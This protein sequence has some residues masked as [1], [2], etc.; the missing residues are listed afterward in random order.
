MPVATASLWMEGTPDAGLPRLEDDLEVEVAVVGGGIVGLL[1]AHALAEAGVEVAVLE[2][3]VVGG[4]VSGHTTAKLTSLHRLIYAELVDRAGEET[5]R[6]HGRANQDGIDAIARLVD[7]LGIE[8]D[9]R[10][11][12]HLT[13]ATNAEE[14]ED[15]RAEARAA[16]RLGLPAE[17]VDETTLPYPVAGAVRFADQAEL[18]PRRFLLGVV[19]ALRARG[20]ALYEHSPATSVDDGDP[21][22]V[23]TPRAAV[24]ARKVVIATHHPF[25]D[26]GLYFARMH[27]ERSYAIA[28]S[29]EEPPPPGMFIS[30]AEPT[31]SL[32][33]HPVDGRELL[34]VGGEGHKV[35][36]GGDTR[37]RYAT[38]EHF[39]REHFAVAGVEYRWS[40]Q[41]NMPADGLP[42]VG[43]LWR[44][45]DRLHTATG[46]RKWGLAQAPPAAELLR[47]LVL[48]R[49]NP[50]AR[51]YDPHRVSL[52]GAPSLV[53]E[54][55]DV[56]LR[57]VGDRVAKRAA[58]S[59]P[60]AAGEGR[61]VSRRGRQVA[62]A[63]DDA[64]ELHAVSARCT[65][66]G[67]IVSFNA[68]ERSWD[69]PCHGSRF[70][71]D[72]DVLQGPAVRPLRR[73]DPP[74]PH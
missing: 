37:E 26:R 53:K 35:G 57:F 6:A 7:E 12:D 30:A 1:T 58:A 45:S 19:D 46:F 51:V 65:H 59:R 62:L 56:A 72:G 18:H 69:C 73:E 13:Y 16:R 11:R 48:G 8:C 47:D 71:L 10:R 40:S 63:R 28:V 61:V 32:R 67:C 24:R 29:L 43:R 55:A 41:D 60:L 42:F 54:N 21:C 39:A 52:R 74:R 14:L 31:R 17:A 9:F 64:G 5:A 44:L 25:L 38:L 33:A 22:T 36:H 70:A 4:G 3:R 2:A 66:L 50:L 27:P 34:I 15:V 49:P 23:R 20:V 68:A